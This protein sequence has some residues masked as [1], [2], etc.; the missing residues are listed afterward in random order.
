MLKRRTFFLL[1]DAALIAASMF[2]SFWVRFDG[3]IPEV[4][5]ANLKYYIAI[6]LAVKLI[7]LLVHDMYD[8]SWRFFGLKDL[9]KLFSAVTLS[10]IVLGLALL[11]VQG[12]RPTSR[13]CPGP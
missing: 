3:V 6:A 11:I 13:L 2:A 10:S 8:V 7:I 5:A 1:S 9:L 4:Y 12:D